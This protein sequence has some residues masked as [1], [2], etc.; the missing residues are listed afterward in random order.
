MYA[1]YL[2]LFRRMW[3]KGLYIVFTFSEHE[4]YEGDRIY[5]RE[6]IVNHKI[7]PLPYFQISY[8]LHKSFRF[9]D[10][11]LSN[12]SDSTYMRDIHSL[13]LYQKIEREFPMTCSKRGIY[14]SDSLS[15]SA[16]N[17]LN[18]AVYK[19][20]LPMSHTIYVYPKQ[21]T[22][23]DFHQFRQRFFGQMISRSLQTEDPFA[24]RGIRE[25]QN[26]DPMR[27]INWKSSAKNNQWM[28]NTFFSTSAK[29]VMLLLD[30]SL[31]NERHWEALCE[32]SIRLAAAVTRELLAAAFSVN[33]VSNAY[34]ADNQICFPPEIPEAGL[35]M[36]AVLRGL[37]R[38]DLRRHLPEPFDTFMEKQIAGTSGQEWIYI[39]ISPNNL[40][41]YQKQYEKLCMGQT[42]FWVDVIDR[43]KKDTPPRS[44][45]STQITKLDWYAET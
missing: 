12:V 34:D 6:I 20:D 10:D 11:R 40:P 35:S 27:K 16:K 32:E 4:A 18:S 24:F 25:Y 33:L 42:A 15:V 2:F 28:V 36:T 29:R 45:A 8:K 23:P 41:E 26:H 9:E 31:V 1:L 19:Q 5:L 39:L 43:E 3:K 22:G 21:I 17:M 30:L 13:W 14:T 38:I 44:V 37:S 7:L